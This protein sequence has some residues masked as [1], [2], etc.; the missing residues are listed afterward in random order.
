[1]LK[2]LS[3]LAL[4]SLDKVVLDYI[5]EN[6]GSRLFQIDKDTI[7]S[8]HNWGAKHIVQRLEDDGKVVVFRYHQGRK[9]APRYYATI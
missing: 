5:K 8:H 2:L 1:M 4:K 9:I 7:Q 6:P 3:T